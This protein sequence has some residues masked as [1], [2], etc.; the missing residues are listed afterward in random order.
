MKGSRRERS[1]AEAQNFFHRHTFIK[2]K[3]SKISLYLRKHVQ[4]SEMHPHPLFLLAALWCLIIYTIPLSCHG[5]AHSRDSGCAEGRQVKFSKGRLIFTAFPDYSSG[6]R[7]CISFPLAPIS[8][9]GPSG[10]PQIRQQRSHSRAELA[11]TSLPF[12][13]LICHKRLALPRQLLR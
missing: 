8:S 10:P 2:E 6:G 12:S 5:T 7:T 9:K 13:H 3:Q 11:M 1:D 4:L